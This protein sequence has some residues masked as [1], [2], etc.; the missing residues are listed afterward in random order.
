MQ[1]PSAES[2]S[3]IKLAIECVL[4]LVLLGLLLHVASKDHTRAA[5]FGLSV[6]G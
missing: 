6:K 5:L 4:L 3:R 2:L 1:W